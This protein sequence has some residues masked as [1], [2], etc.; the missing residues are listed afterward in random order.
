[1]NWIK[2]AT[3][4]GNDPKVIRIANA[5]GVGT[6]HAVG[7]IVLMLTGVA[8][9]Q[10]DGDL[11][12]VPDDAVEVWAQWHGKGKKRGAFAAAVRAQLCDSQ[13]VI[14]AWDRHNGSAM[15]DNER[16]RL[17][18]KEWRERKRAAAR[19]TPDVTVTL[20]L[21]NRG[22]YD[23]IRYDTNSNN[24]NNKQ[25]LHHVA[26]APDATLFDVLHVVASDTQH[27]VTTGSAAEAGHG[28]VTTTAPS[29]RRRKG[30]PAAPRRGRRDDA[31]A[32]KPEV[33]FPH[34]TL[35]AR[36]EVFA[37]WK[38]ERGATSF[39]EL[40]KAFAPF[41]LAPDAPDVVPLDRILTAIRTY[42]Q[43]VKH[44]KQSPFATPRH[45]A[46]VLGVI[47]KN[48]VLYERVDRRAVDFMA[49]HGHRE[50]F[51]NGAG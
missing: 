34:F 26:D 21:A 43:L 35:D 46:S 20:P 7:H 39:P 3:N 49:I 14:V 45:C 24:N 32:A 50:A 18:Q 6:P 33:Q 47:L 38:A 19:A 17:R 22:R 44:G 5:L 42:L 13:G 15:R 36:A 30:D 9:S 25:H 23:T 10:Q 27:A 41:F 31:D 12:R 28:V 4:I 51:D 40:V 29:R 48:Q 2:I 1:M 11:S 8:G 37:L 16:N